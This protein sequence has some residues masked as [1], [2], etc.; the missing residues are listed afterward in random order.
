MTSDRKRLLATMLILGCGAKMAKDA[1][2]P[3]PAEMA[4]PYQAAG[5]ETY[6]H[7]DENKPVS[8]DDAPLS[9]F[10][11]DVDTASYANVRRFLRNGQPPPAD[12]VRIEELVNYFDYAYP[13]PQDGTPM[14]M[15][16]EVGPCPWDPSHELVHIGLQGRRIVQDKAPPANLVFLIDVSG[17]MADEDKL[18]LVK[19][20]LRKLARNLR[21]E[22]RLAIVVYAGASGLVLPPTSGVNQERILSALGALEAGGSTNGGEGIQLA[23]RVAEEAFRRGGVN[24]VVLATDGDFNVGTTSFEALE[25]LI[26]E[27]R[28]TGVYLTVLGVGTGNLRD[29]TMEMLAD[30]G[31]GNYHYLDSL[32]EANKVL[33]AEASGT[34]VTIAEDVKVQVE[35]NRQRVESYRLIGYENRKLADQDF[36]DDRKDAGDLGAGHNVTAIYEIVPAKGAGA[37]AEVMKLRLRYKDPGGQES[38]LLEFSVRGGAAEMADTSPDFRFSAAV[39]AWGMLLKGSEFK[40]DVSAEMIAAL[41]APAAGDDVHRREF[42]QLVDAAARLMG[43]RK[44]LAQ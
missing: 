9:T 11:I 8:V 10:A 3:P 34:L 42:L 15:T 39:A 25:R 5:G 21:E 6:A 31:N 16:S 22:D 13:A 32:A 29:A 28:Q 12:A 27:K 43:E 41:A 44:A 38:K 14:A 20:S 30:K 26:E 18:P 1:S 17:S 35:F 36:K 23:Y 2:A 24:R 37:E 19:E 40:A 33:V 4:A 7:V